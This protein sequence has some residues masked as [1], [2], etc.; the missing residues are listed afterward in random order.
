MGGDT[1]IILIIITATLV[2]LVLIIAIILFA[3]VYNKKLGER[4]YLHSIE[5]KSKELDLLRAVIETQETER[6]K[7]ARNL[8]DEVGVLI[9][10][11]KL[12]LTLHQK[13]LI[14]N[15]LAAEALNEER[16]MTDRLMDCVRTVSHDLTP[17]FLMKNG[18]L[19]SLDK[20]LSNLDG[21]QVS[22]ERNSVQFPPM[23][24]FTEVNIYRMLLELI[25]NI[26][27]H[28]NCKSLVL[29]IESSE[30]KIRF[31]LKHDGAGISNEDFDLLL[32]RKDGLGLE[33]IKARAILL[34][35][36][37]S[38]STIPNA[39]FTLEVPVH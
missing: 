20:Y 31:K 24:V 15:Q 11:L 6:E 30:G 9:T 29:R 34:N 33:S 26:V 21:I 13:E 27:K 7:I 23:E 1:T 38:Y 37:L 5:L 8:H 22:F 32:K 19:K 25:N 3:V 18:L 17:R 4:E 12:K 36:D 2:M 10:G 35:A 28:D 39:G 14:K 16:E